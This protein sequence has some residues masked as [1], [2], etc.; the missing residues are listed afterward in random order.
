VV[1]R[2]IVQVAGKEKQK[3]DRKKN[4]DNRKRGERRKQRR[5]K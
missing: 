3:K 2:K 5:E 1:T 4:G